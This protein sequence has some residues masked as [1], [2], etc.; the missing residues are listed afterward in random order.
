MTEHLS[1][2]NL[3]TVLA[4]DME[5]LV[6]SFEAVEVTELNAEQKTWLQQLMKDLSRH[7]L[8]ASQ[9]LEQS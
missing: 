4:T 8:H 5:C 9:L 3:F 6:E 7:M 1:P 2:N